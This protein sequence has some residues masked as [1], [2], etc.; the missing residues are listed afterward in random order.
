MT[1]YRYTEISSALYRITAPDD[2][3][4]LEDMKKHLRVGFDDDDDMIEAYTLAATQYVD[5]KD[6]V[7]GRALGEQTWE[8][9]LS[10]F[11]C[12]NIEI[13]LP[14]L[15][16]VV[17]V[18][19]IDEDDTEQTYD[20]AKYHVVGEG[21]RGRISLVSDETWPTLGSGWPEPVIVQFRAGYIDS[22][23][24][25]PI[26]A[27]PEPILAAIKLLTGNLYANRETIVVGQVAVEL[28]WAAEALLRAYRVYS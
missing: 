9:R 4:S 10:S 20:A 18:K 22:S 16:E 7:L 28:P 27:V 6:G 19:Y 24:S 15:I 2:L 11:P 21:G 3:I 5:G 25:P 14:P 23:V 26:A 1:V 17:S 8:M 13:P 12:G